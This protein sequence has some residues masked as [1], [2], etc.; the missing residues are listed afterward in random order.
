M[1]RFYVLTGMSSCVLLFYFCIVFFYTHILVFLEKKC[2][3]YFDQYLNEISFVKIPDLLFQN[4][5]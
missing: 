4:V 3:Y 1:A 5:L 2:V